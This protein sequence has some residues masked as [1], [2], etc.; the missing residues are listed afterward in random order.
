MA[1]Q[2]RLIECFKSAADCSCLLNQLVAFIDLEKYFFIMNSGIIISS[3]DQLFKSH[4][5]VIAIQLESQTRPNG[6]RV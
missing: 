5:G 6:F 1:Y 3:I 4:L 2:V